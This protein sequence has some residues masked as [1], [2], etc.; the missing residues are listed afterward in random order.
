MAKLSKLFA[1][2]QGL[3]TIFVGAVVLLYVA[4]VLASHGGDPLAFVDY[5]GHFAY[6]IAL[7]WT[8]AVS[9]LDVPAYRFQRIFYPLLA[10]IVALGQSGL[11]P[12]ALIGVNMAAIGIGTWATEGLLTRLGVSGWYA[13][14]YG[15]YGGQFVALRTNLTE[16]VA[17][18]LIMLAMLAW[19]QKRLY[20]AVLAFALAALTKE[21]TLIFV[22]AYGLYS[23]RER[24]WGQAV[25]LSLSGVPF[26]VMQIILW[27]W[28]GAPGVGSGGA[29]ATSFTL[30]PFGGWLV[31]A[32]TGWMAFLLVSL[33]IVPMV[34]VPVLF[35]LGIS[36]QALWRGLHHP[37]VYCL[38][39]NGLVILFLPRSTL[40]E[41]AAMV[42]FM[43]AVMVSLLLYG[44]LVH[45]RRILNYSVL[46]IFTNV[47][48]VKGTA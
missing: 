40:Q 20:W 37:Y 48:W 44:G 46:W 32:Q 21:T 9:Y 10:R 35:A 3:P 11:V 25:L 19:T 16:P 14:V 22:A 26:L 24:A 34:V 13:L 31:V 28:L 2:R 23:L 42:R 1:Y 47:I 8:T 27:Y 43:Q 5:D 17:Q 29:G 36:L 15:L 4:G 39:L 7:R 41:A 18:A 38:L 33:T 45:S 30:V 12:W 6:Q